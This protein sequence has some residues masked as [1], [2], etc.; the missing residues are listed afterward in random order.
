M[1]FPGINNLFREGELGLQ[2]ILREATIEQQ[3]NSKDAEIHQF[4][5]CESLE[6]PHLTLGLV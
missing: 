5:L 6:F 4:K 1:Q 3:V 2:K